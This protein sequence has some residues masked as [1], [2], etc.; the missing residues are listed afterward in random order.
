MTEITNLEKEEILPE[1]EYWKQLDL[2]F[3]AYNLQVQQE[4]LKKKLKELQKV[5][6]KNFSDQNIQQL[7]ALKILVNELIQKK[8]QITSKILDSFN[9]YK[10]RQEVSNLRGYTAELN[11]AFKRKKIDV[12]TYRIT[13]DYY[14]KQL[15]IH[16]KN[17]DRLNLVAKEYILILRN[18]EIEL[19]SEYNYKNGR[20]LKKN[21]KNVSKDYK[22]RKNVIKQKINFLNAE[23]IDYT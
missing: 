10:I 2:L 14:N 11:K 16:I 22:N 6:K 5:I 23:I 3:E 15:K 18:E 13:N 7:N 20:K 1:N 4:R 12:N 8:D 21:Q 19:N 9:I 17:L